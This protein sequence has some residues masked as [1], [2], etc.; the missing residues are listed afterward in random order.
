MCARP[1]M[2]AA[3][4][5][6]QLGYVQIDTLAVVQRSHHLTMW[7]RL[8][9][10]Q[11]KIL[12]DL[13]A[14]ERKIFEYW[15]HA[16]SYVPMADYR[17][18]LP[19]MRN[20][21]KPTHKWVLAK[22]D[23]CKQYLKPVL[24]RIREE[25]PLGAKDFEKPKG[26][27]GSWWDWKPAK[28]ALEFLVWRGD[29]MVAYRQNFHKR[30][31]LTERVLPAGTDTR[32]PSP[33]EVGQ[34]IVRR[35]I[36]SMGVM[37][38]PDLCAYLQPGNARDSDFHAVDRKTLLT[39]LRQLVEAE[40]IIPV[41][42]EPDP[43]RTYYVQRAGLT[44]PKGKKKEKQLFLL[45]PFDNLIIQR[46]RCRRIFGF[47]YALECYVPALKRKVGYFVMPIL[48]DNQL[49]GRLDPKADRK[50]GTLHI[51]NLVLEPGFKDL[52]AFLPALAKKLCDFSEFNGCQQVDIV[53][54]QPKKITPILKRLLRSG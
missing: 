46:E 40:E 7:A 17:Y 16:M 19:R 15:T 26:K 27:N 13:Q 30:Y 34:F 35:A 2:S 47:D 53:K 21:K 12:D 45:S 31:D 42:I 4:L 5:V 11:P 32:M 33:Q 8:P 25:G 28:M 9:R 36:K 20:F 41:Q 44:R 43:K 18:Y 48:W 39:V 50:T 24:Q 10:Y 52:D 54:T 1:R 6:E 23:P 49:V 29:L 37:S 38:E 14:K 3:K 22:L 51:L